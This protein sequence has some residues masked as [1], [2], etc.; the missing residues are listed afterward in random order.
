MTANYSLLGT[1]VSP[2]P[3]TSGNNVQDDNPLL[4]PLADNGGPTLTHALLLDSA[5]INAGSNA[6]AV[7]QEGIP[8]ATDQ[9]GSGF[10]RIQVGTVDIGAFE[11]TFDDVTPPTIVSV[12]I[13]EGGVLA[14][15]DLWNT[16]T[17]VFDT[18]VD[19]SANALTL[20]NDLPTG[21]PVALDLTG[22]GF[23]YD[24]SANT[25]IWD[26]STLDPLLPGIY[27]YQLDANLINAG[28]VTLDSDGDG[29][30]GDDF[31]DQ[32]YVAIPGDV[33]LDGR[34][35]VLNDAFALVGNLNTPSGAIYADG[36]FNGDGQVDILGDAFILVANLNRN[37]DLVTDVV[38][39]NN[40]DLVN[41]NTSSVFALIA[42]DGGDGI[43]LREAI[44]ASNNA[45]GSGT[46]TF[47]ESVFV[48]GADSLI[49]LTQGE[50][51]ITEGLAIDASAA[52]DVTITGDANG[53]DVMVAGT[54]VTDVGASFG[55]AAGD[56]DDLLDDN[57]RVLNFS[58]T[59]GDLTLAGLTL[60]GGRTT[61]QDGGGV[62]FR[63]DE[64]LTIEDSL[65]AGN[66]AS[67]EF[68]SGGGVAS[69]SGNI[70]LL[71]STVSNNSTSGDGFTSTGSGIF[72]SFANTGGGG[73]STNSGS[74]S[75]INSTISNNNTSGSDSVGG[76][77]FSA[78]GDVLLDNS[79]VVGNNTSG[80]ISQGGGIAT[81]SGDILLLDSVI[82]NNSTTGFGS[83]GG[84]VS[85]SQGSVS[86][87]NSSLSGNSTSGDLSQGG[88]IFADLGN[89]SLENS[90]L[91]DNSTSGFYSPGGG[92]FVSEFAFFS[93]YVF[94]SV[95]LT[96][97]TISG[98]TTNGTYSRGGGIYSES[99]S[100]S[101]TNSTVTGN[102]A[103][104]NYAVEFL[105][106][107]MGEVN[108]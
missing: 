31:V 68:S 18:D 4:A 82:S 108:R 71:N 22:I 7:D 48:G 96:N 40:T 107:M 55:G 11:S 25:A 101:L 24:A 61:T 88:G 87:V 93:P 99:G 90:V 74:V 92:I 65:I 12:S 67:G 19:V 54:F 58:G 9:R 85:T 56:V 72:P 33:N 81:N 50:L 62:Y 49:R 47:D 46:V 21:N 102:S 66:S 83:R 3:D 45:I 36:D 76:G 30:R 52:T 43:S 97:S 44:I 70:L 29:V 84:G 14:R 15:P 59:T 41:A 51:E 16:L 23:T 63:S 75:L 17:V 86:L 57:S 37:V 1:D 73:I 32:H 79:S 38:V 35:D 95:S 103:T 106:P 78:S 20:F 2:A 98:N 64:S 104:N 91:H 28:N 42:D 80:R 100:I 34:V 69:D 26:F 77:I 8:F 6:L 94:N 27:T 13:N 60:T 105:S 39:S 53:D 10:D 5:A 89:V